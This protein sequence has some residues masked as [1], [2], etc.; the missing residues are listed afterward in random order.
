MLGNQLGQLIQNLQPGIDATDQLSIVESLL[1]S[2]A[3]AADTSELLADLLSTLLVP[4]E[5]Q[6][7]VH[8][9]TKEEEESQTQWGVSSVC[10]DLSDA[11]VSKL[12]SLTCAE[13]SQKL[14]LVT[15][16]VLYC[17]FQQEH[18]KAISPLTAKRESLVTSAF[19]SDK[20]GLL[21][22]VFQITRSLLSTDT[23][24]PSK[25]K[26]GKDLAS[27]AFSQHTTVCRGSTD[28]VVEQAYAA[29]C[30][31]NLKKSCQSN[32]HASKLVDLSLLSRQCDG[33]FDI[34]SP[35]T[36]CSKLAC[37]VVSEEEGKKLLDHAVSSLS[38]ASVK[39]A[40]L[41]L[42]R[43]LVLLEHFLSHGISKLSE[44]SLCD[45]EL[46]SSNEDNRELLK[47]HSYFYLLTQCFKSLCGIDS[48]GE[49]I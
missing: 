5:N 41:L 2:S 16:S 27:R 33:H 7:L 19:I 45:L 6:E 46:C 10:A 15:Y 47:M 20:D 13:S 23:K 35:V 25:S 39:I 36:G 29:E 42:Q 32:I 34:T 12:I 18:L 9:F 3:G 22:T 31:N 49:Y 30:V 44:V 1:T 24:S 14:D 43:S 37:V 48:N 38:P 17:K 8:S 21:S 11:A 4:P 40:G 26:C 28:I